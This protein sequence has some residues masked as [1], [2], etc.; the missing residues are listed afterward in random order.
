ML[1]SAYKLQKLFIIIFFFFLVKLV[2][3]ARRKVKMVASKH[4]F[5]ETISEHF[6][7]TK[8]PMDE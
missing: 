4:I 3:V 5:L 7:D 6:R 1:H 8:Q 2:K